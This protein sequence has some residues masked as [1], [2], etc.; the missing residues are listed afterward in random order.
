MT[1]H[2]IARAKERLGIEVDQ[3]DFDAAIAICGRSHRAVF[4]QR[5]ANGREHWLVP[6]KG[7]IAGLVVIE[8]S[9]V[10]VM[11]PAQITAAGK[12]GDIARISTRVQ[13]RRGDWRTRDDRI[14]KRQK[15][16]EA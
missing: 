9:V 2:A 10:T 7:V 14:T 8:R 3:R 6:L 15:F 12:R 4:V 5:E 16:G 13:K 1:A 11:S